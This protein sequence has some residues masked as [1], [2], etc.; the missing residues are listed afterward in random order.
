MHFLHSDTAKCLA[1]V[2]L[3]TVAGFAQTKPVTILPGLGNHHHPIST[4]NPEAQRYFDQGFALVY[5]FNHDE[6]VRAFKRAAEL[7]PKA[8][9]PHW[10]IALA[11]GP[12]INMPI[13]PDAEKAAYEAVQKAQSL[14]AGAPENERAYIAALVTRYSIDPKADLKKLA[15]DYKNAMGKLVER[16]PDDLDA[17]T[18]FAES[19]MD[20]HP[21]ALWSA[22][23][24]PAEGTLEIQAVLES[25]LKRNP[26]HPG[27]NHYYIHTVE[28]SPHPEQALPSAGRL[29]GLMPGAGHLVHMPAHIFIRTGDF[30]AAEKTNKDAAAADRS[31]IATTGV[32]GVYPMMY[33]SHNL[34][35]IVEACKFSGRSAEAKKAAEQLVANVSPGVAMMAPLEAFMPTPYFVALRFNRWDE[36]AKFPAP[37]ASQKITTAFYHF[38]RGIGFAAAKQMPRAESE[39]ASFDATV[40]SIPESAP[41]GLNTAPA[42]LKVAA[43]VLEARIAA[44]KG[45]RSGAIAAWRKAVEAQD[46]LG[47]DEPADWYYPIRESLGAALFLAGN[48]QEAEKV[49]RADLDKNPRNG[50]SLFGLAECL[51][52]QRKTTDAAWIATEF[53]SAWKN[54]DVKLRMEDL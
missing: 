18:L 20:L 33:Y 23:G 40:K 1:L 44:A 54:A 36:V 7:D 30:E 17:A 42:V 32:M 11:L 39:K 14:A 27:A 43:A 51:K 13:E 24:K 26:S 28:A 9:M 31:Y 45:D 22:D 47:Y 37:P 4:T 52:A 16:Y 53:E 8:A 48:H 2:A 6:A 12:N 25:V 5:G 50:R 29:A 34:H 46:A 10:G 41:Y 19:A 3:L 21:W 38:A 35:F 49:F 15:V